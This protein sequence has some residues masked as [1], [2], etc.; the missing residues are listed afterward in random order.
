[1]RDL[2]CIASILPCHVSLKV[3]NTVL[4]STPYGFSL[5][6]AA[7]A[8]ARNYLN[9]EAW[10]LEHMKRDSMQFITALMTFLDAR[11]AVSSVQGQ[12]CFNAFGGACQ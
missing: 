9:L 10:A 2:W 3:L 5:E 12:L 4:D 11:T 8:A 1:M 7:T 6:L